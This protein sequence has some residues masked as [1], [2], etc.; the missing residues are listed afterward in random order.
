MKRILIMNALIDWNKFGA[1]VEVKILE[2]TKSGSIAFIEDKDKLNSWEIYHTHWEDWLS[3]SAY[4]KNWQEKIN[5]FQTPKEVGFYM[6]R[7]R[8]FIDFVK[9][10]TRKDIR[11]VKDAKP[12]DP[13][14]T[15]KLIEQ[16]LKWLENIKRI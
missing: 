1:D 13:I 11:Y 15:P 7:L 9:E 16:E 6:N 10:H 4:F 3:S 5:S 14:N 12:R 2:N 8:V